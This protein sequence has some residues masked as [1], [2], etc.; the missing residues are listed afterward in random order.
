MLIEIIQ[1]EW[2]KG[3]GKRVTINPFTVVQMIRVVKWYHYKLMRQDKLNKKTR[4]KGLLKRYK[5]NH[6][7][8]NT[9]IYFKK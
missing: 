8:K 2:E 6:Q 7:D 9:I 4:I 3:V 1:L 5:G